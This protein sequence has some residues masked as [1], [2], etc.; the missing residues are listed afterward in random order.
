MTVGEL[1]KALDLDVLSQSDPDRTVN[2]AYAGDLLSWVMGRA[3]EGCVWATIMTNVNVLAVASLVDTAATVI[4][5]NSEVSDDIIG[6]A[7]EKSVNLFR[8]AMPVYEF[9]VSLSEFLK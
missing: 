9:C 7:K 8:T 2:G 1:V 3:T 5:E 6:T 4:C